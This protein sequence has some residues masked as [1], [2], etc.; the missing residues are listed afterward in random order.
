MKGLLAEAL[1]LPPSQRRVFVNRLA[2]D[3]AALAEELGSLLDAAE[4]SE[5]LLDRLPTVLAAEVDE[6][7]GASCIGQQLGSY[8]VV[9]LIGRGGMGEVYR[10]ERADGQYEQQVAIKL[11]GHS[12]DREH[13]ISRFHAERQILA[14]LDHPNLAKVF[15]GGVTEDGRPYFVMELVDGE[16]I[17]LY[18][19]RRK[20]PVQQRLQ[21]FRTVCQVAHYAHSK[22]VVHRDLKPSNILVSGSGAVKLLDFGIAKRL[23]SADGAPPTNTRTAQRVLTLAYSSPEQVQ[24]DEISPTSDIYSLGVVL[25]RL[26]TGTSPYLDLPTS[27]DYELAKAICDGEPTP[28]SKAVTERRLRAQLR[29]DLDAVVLKALRKDP[30]ARY[31]SAEHLADDVFR[32]LERLP[33]HARRGAWSYRAGRFVQHHRVAV[34]VALVANLAMIGGLTVAVYQAYEA[35]RERERAERHFADVRQLANVFIFDIHDAILTLPGSTPVRR[36]VVEKALAYLQKLS[37]EAGGDAGLLVEIAAGYR[38]VAEAIGGGNGPNLGDAKEAMS[39]FEKARELLEP[40][41]ASPSRRNAAFRAAQQELVNVYRHQASLLVRLGKFK[42]ADAVFRSGLS[43][44]GDLA[45]A[46]PTFEN[47]RRLA[48]LYGQQSTMQLYANDQD[49]YVKTSDTSIRLLE[50]LVAQR[51]GNDVAEIYLSNVYRVRGEYLSAIQSFH[52]AIPYYR[53]SLS[54]LMRL[55]V[56]DADNTT[57]IHGIAICHAGLGAAF[58]RAGDSK[59]AVQEYR[60]AIELSSSLLA[61]DPR[62]IVNRV[63]LAA[64]NLSMSESL[65]SQGDVTGSIHA[66]KAALTLLANLPKGASMRFDVRKIQ[67]E[68]HY[69][70]GKALVARAGGRSYSADAFHSDRQ[71]ACLSYRQALSILQGLKDSAILA[72][73]DVQ[74]EQVRKAMQ[75]CPPSQ[76]R[77]PA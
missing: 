2:A 61:K 70:L 65:L 76:S 41:T 15:D 42:E 44:A 68:T 37:S 17:D 57:L 72:P 9:E 47:R 64:V 55:R 11:M 1:T 36:L 34:G 6:L 43:V 51:P 3:D 77:A 22:G 35:N 56:R 40:L 39:N 24:G 52:Q 12:F 28:P 62:E 54:I 73:E 20:L 66:G 75:A 27:S 58:Q 8:R 21:L 29:G 60:Q 48:G 49:A 10:A 50:A 74:P 18:A 19:E 45:T 31:A 14:S 71:G 30:A 7:R 46:A 23:G 69:H 26:L 67:G 16:P 63:T 59:Q 13:A 33:V 4:A 53:K 5:T 32:H 38:R 25:H